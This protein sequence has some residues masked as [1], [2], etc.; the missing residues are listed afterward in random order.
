MNRRY[1][2]EIEQRALGKGYETITQALNDRHVVSPGGTRWERSTV[3][4]IVHNAVYCGQ[5]V[6]RE[7]KKISKKGRRVL[8]E[9][10]FPGK[11][12]PIISM[13]LWERVQRVNGNRKRDYT[14]GHL[15]THLLSGL[16]RCAFCGDAMVYL[17]VNRHWMSLRCGRYGRSQGR[18][19]C[20]NS[21]A[22][23]RIETFVLQAVKQVLADPAA[24]AAARRQAVKADAVQQRIEHLQ[25]EI[26]TLDNRLQALYD[27]IETRRFPIEELAKR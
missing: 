26:K 22:A 25:E 27:A 24:F 14:H 6:L 20:S 9:E 1:L 17:N 16:C 2:K 7:Y 8:S 15:P 5:I 13:E 21:A 18:E 3:R 19:C 12:E 23:A 4:Y 11:H 10:V